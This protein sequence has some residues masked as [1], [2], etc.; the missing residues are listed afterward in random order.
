MLTL[1]TSVRKRYEEKLKM[2]TVDIKDKAG[3]VAMSLI[4]PPVSDDNILRFNKG[5]L[6]QSKHKSERGHGIK[7]TPGP[8]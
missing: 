5:S 6:R 7:N 1:S 2:L 3:V 4:E 8:R